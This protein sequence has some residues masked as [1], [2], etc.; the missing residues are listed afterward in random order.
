MAPGVL[1][2]ALRNSGWTPTKVKQTAGKLE[3]K[4]GSVVRLPL[5][6]SLKHLITDSKTGKGIVKL[7]SAKIIKGAGF[8]QGCSLNKTAEKHDGLLPFLLVLLIGLLQK[9][10]AEIGA[11]G[12][13]IGGTLAVDNAV[14]NKQYQTK[15]LEKQSRY[16]QPIEEKGC[17]SRYNQE[18]NPIPSK[19]VIKY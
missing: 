2:K 16:N 7:L 9:I 13:V 12:S 1:A 14:H 3:T 18:K 5:E 15:K 6:F 8:E 19:T 11:I 4:T 10:V 17:V